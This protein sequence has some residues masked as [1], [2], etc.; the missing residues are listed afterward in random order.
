[1]M[2]GVIEE[3]LPSGRWMRK[4]L[5]RGLWTTWHA[6]SWSDDILDYGQLNCNVCALYGMTRLAINHEMNWL[7]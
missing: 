3:M 4:G 5:W 1:M 2:V 7:E 6:Y